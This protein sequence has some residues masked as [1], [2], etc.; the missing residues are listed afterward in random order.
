MSPLSLLTRRRLAGALAGAA[1]LLPGAGAH[2]MRQHGAPAPA[3][4][5]PLTITLGGP[6]A[7]AVPERF[8]GLSFEAQSIPDLARYAAAGDLA[9]LLRSLGPSVLRLGGV[10]ADARVAY[11]TPASAAP[12]W[13]STTIS[14]GD[15]SGLAALARETDARILLTVGLA[16]DDPQA[17]AR[18]A[19]A[20]QA[21]LGPSLQAIEIGNEPDAFGAHGLRPLPWTFGAYATEI[22]AYRAAIA[23]AAP[24]LAIAGPDTTGA[25]FAVWGRAEAHVVR[26]ALLTAHRYPL[27]CSAVPAPSIGAL[28]SPA[29][30]ARDLAQLG[31]DAAIARAAGIPLRI[32]ETNSVSCGGRAGVSNTF[33]AALWAVRL[34]AEAMQLGIAGVNF[35][36]L[37][38]NCGGY[39]PLCA[40]GPAALTGGRLRAAPEWYALL[41]TRGL[42]GERPLATTVRRAVGTITAEAFGGGGRTRVLL[43]DSAAGGAPAPVR[44]V[45]GRAPATATVLALTAPS[46]AATSGVRIGGHAVNASGELVG[47]LARGVVHSAGGAITVPL[48]PG[49]AA[50]VTVAGGR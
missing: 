37:P 42:I 27:V 25:S 19:A 36:D 15:L 50:L 30:R 5:L 23:R 44:I 16:H 13:A 1:A 12:S 10:T 11:A 18:E 45:T 41:F 7:A 47:P 24:G 3:A 28:L 38:A 43:V 6:S 20:A 21:A 14:A 29:T 35:H 49:S 17:G 2:A 33:A 8:L 31:S 22:G 39:S 26:P 4:P 9:A 46:L 34:I 40:T 32:D 48:A